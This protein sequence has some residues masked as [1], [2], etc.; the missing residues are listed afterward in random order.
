MKKIRDMV[1]E[2]KRMPTPSY[3][4]CQ[5]SENDNGF[6]NISKSVYDTFVE[7]VNDCLAQ[8]LCKCITYYFDN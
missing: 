1:C 8:S 3:K 6:N 2:G 5:K 4:K 7:L